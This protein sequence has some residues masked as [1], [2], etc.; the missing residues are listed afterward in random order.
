MGNNSFSHFSRFEQSTSSAPNAREFQPEQNVEQEQQATFSGRPTISYDPE[1]SYL[2][3]L[4]TSQAANLRAST[5]ATATNLTTARSTVQDSP[6][7]DYLANPYLTAPPF[8]AATSTS[9]SI[10]PGSTTSGSVIIDPPKDPFALLA[11]YQPISFEEGQPQLYSGFGILDD[12][13]G[14]FPEELEAAHITGQPAGQTM[15]APVMD[16]PVPHSQGVDIPP[17]LGQSDAAMEKTTEQTSHVSGSFPADL[18]EGFSEDPQK[19]QEVSRQDNNPPVNPPAS[20]Q[21][22]ASAP[23]PSVTAASVIPLS[24]AQPVVGPLSSCSQRPSQPKLPGSQAVSPPLRIRGKIKTRKSI[25]LQSDKY[26]LR[27]DSLERRYMCGYPN[28]GKTYTSS[29]HLRVHVFTH[30]GISE[31]RCTYPQC[32]PHK[33]FC[34]KRELKR[35]IIM[36]HLQRHQWQC[37]VCYRIFKSL[38]TL[39]AHMTEKHHVPLLQ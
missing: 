20:Y 28:C 5:S 26:L 27:I 4:F 2:T 21:G 22:D 6:A 19:M 24:L 36:A 34:N 3:S 37:V 16:S 23:V 31:H 25:E 39:K 30:T 33:Y 13:S 11:A 7:T 29:G 32:G 8:L 1:N 14:A 15:R 12:F 35:H 17:S 9:Q 18:L 10:T 38:K